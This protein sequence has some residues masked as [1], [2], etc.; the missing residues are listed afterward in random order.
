M[1]F[2]ID[3][4]SGWQKSE[5]TLNA[6]CLSSIVPPKY[7]LQAV[8]QLQRSLVARAKEAADQ[9]PKPQKDSSESDDLSA[10]T[11]RIPADFRK[12]KIS[13]VMQLLERETALVDAVA[14]RLGRLRGI[15]VS[16]PVL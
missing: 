15:G 12:Q 8:S 5:K 16:T 3:I 4:E 10:S 14:D 13:Q 2:V 7:H 6:G 11:S 1:F 9:Q